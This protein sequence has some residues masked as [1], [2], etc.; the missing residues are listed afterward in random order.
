MGVKM[1][2]ILQFYKNTFVLIS[3]FLA[4]LNL[5]IS[6]SKIPNLFFY[7]SLGYQS[8]DL[9]NLNSKL[10]YYNLPELATDYVPVGVGFF[11]FEQ[12]DFLVGIEGFLMRG[13]TQSNSKFKTNLNAKYILLNLGYCLASKNSLFII[14]IVGIGG[15]FLSIKIYE[16]NISN[17]DDVMANPKRGAIL[18]QETLMI[19]LSLELFYF[20]KP[21]VLGIN[22][23]YTKHGE[24]RE[25]ELYDYQIDGSPQ[26]GITGFY[27]KL[28]YGFAV[29]FK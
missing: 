27:I 25:W 9:R 17:F 20:S 26:A 21:N 2:I 15:N 3:I 10:N 12:D 8:I 23:G 22:I 7:F 1:K 14:P 18:N 24:Y 13:V 28:I 29:N 4:F 16:K 11:G 19:N 5:G 6:Q